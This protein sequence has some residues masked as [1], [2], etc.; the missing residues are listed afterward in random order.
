[1]KGYPT[2]KYFKDGQFAFDTPDLRDEERIVE[3]MK[4]PK[5]P[6][7]PPPPEPSWADVP[8]EVLHLNQQNFMSQLR[9][10]RHALVMFYAPCKYK[11]FLLVSTD[12]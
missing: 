4:N 12:M 11:N 2:I 6:P 7:P 9:S 5:E 10:K 3:F 1:M 8:S